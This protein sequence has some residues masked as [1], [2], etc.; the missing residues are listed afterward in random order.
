MRDELPTTDCPRCGAPLPPDGSRCAYCQGVAA[1][2]RDLAPQQLE[3]LEVFVRSVEEKL[4]IGKNAY[5]GRVF[6]TFLVLNALLIGTGIALALTSLPWYAIAGL[7][8]VLALGLLIVWGGLIATL[9][10]R[11]VREAYERRVRDDIAAHLA[12][13]GVARHQ[14]DTLAAKVLPADALLRPFLFD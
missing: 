12:A 8:S 6:S 3:D 1:V 7:V 2:T 4:K 11:A 5:D 9:E 13:T 10:T 14:F